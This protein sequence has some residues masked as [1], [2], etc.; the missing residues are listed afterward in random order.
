MKEAEKQRKGVRHSLFKRF[1]MIVVILLLCM[2]GSFLAVDYTVRKMAES[3]TL[4]SNEK[5][6][7]QIDAKT[8]E[9]HNSIYNM[10]TLL[11]YEQTTY[12]YFTQS[13]RERLGS[14]EDLQ[15]LLSNMMMIQ[16]DIAG[17]S[18]YDGEGG[19]LTT[20]GKD[21]EVFNRA[22]VETNFAYFQCFSA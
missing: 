9:F 1:L 12:Q 3:S 14:Y 4:S 5:I 22:P 10:L 11:A 7:Q 8:K 2:I 6:L 21:F 18:L 20:L 13:Q 16:N 19:K 17:I 15:I